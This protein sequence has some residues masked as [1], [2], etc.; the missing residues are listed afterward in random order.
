MILTRFCPAKVNLFLEV[1]G[2]RPNGYHE[3]ATL[4]A[5]IKLGDELTLDIEPAEE[6]SLSLTLSGPVGKRLRADE[7]NLV[8]RAARGF[9]EHFKLN[10]CVEMKLHKRVPTGAGLGGGSSDAAGTLLALCD[11]FHK[12]KKELL[13]LAATLGADVPLFMY[14]ESFLKGEGIGEILTPV[15]T[16][17]QLPWLVLIYPNA[18]ISTKTVFGNFVLPT[19]EEIDKNV[20]R[21]TQ[22][23]H[24][25]E[26]ARPLADWENFLFNRLEENVASV[27]R[28]VQQALADLKKA[29]AKAVLMSGSGSTVFALTETADEAEQLARQVCSRERT[30]FC[31]PFYTPSAAGKK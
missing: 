18:F 6:T 30:V 28:P 24:C 14:E 21:L 22:L 19:K 27:S 23:I 4:F 9:L 7:T 26:Q 13:P 15:S 10:A 17:G 12:D 5:K 31:T 25:V 3:L 11:F 29:G 1:T 16:G 8:C 20:T 2:K